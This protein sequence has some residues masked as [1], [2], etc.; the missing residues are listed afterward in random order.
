MGVIW[1]TKIW[2]S[3][4]REGACDGCLVPEYK[5]GVACG[6]NEGY[7]EG[8]GDGGAMGDKGADVVGERWKSI[9]EKLCFNSFGSV[10]FFILRPRPPT[11]VGAQN[12]GIHPRTPSFF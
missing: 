8:M 5:G 7:N 1:G 2:G 4:G 6:E 3:S 9:R 10:F 11:Y 12:T